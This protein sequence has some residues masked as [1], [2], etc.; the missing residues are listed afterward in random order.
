VPNVSWSPHS[1]RTT[2]SAGTIAN[3]FPSVGRVT[4]LV[5]DG[6]DGNGQWGGRVTSITVR[7]TSGDATTTGIGFRSAFG[8]RSEWFRVVLP[9]APPTYVR[10]TRAGS[11]ATVSWR[12][13]SPNGGATITGYTVRLS[14]GGAAKSVGTAARTA[15]FSGLST[16]TDYVASVVATSGVGPSHA[17]TVTTKVRRLGGA[18]TIRAAAAVSRA[19]F[20]DDAAKAVVLV[21]AGHRA[22]AMS[23]GPLAAA[24]H[25][26]V[27]V[28]E[29]STLPGV[30]G[31][32]L[33][34]VAPAGA[35][36]YLLGN[37]GAI[38]D[39]VATTVQSD[40][41]HPARVTGDTTAAAAVAVAHVV[42]RTTTVSAAYEV[43]GGSYADAWSATPAAVRAHAVL[44]VTN[45]TAQAP[46]TAAWI[47][48]HSGLPRFAVGADAQQADPAATAVGGAGS[49]ATAIALA[50]STFSSPRLV[51]VLA[52]HG[53]TALSAA[54]RL[55]RRG[56]LVYAPSGVLP[57]GV[58]SYLA[59]HRGDIVGVELVGGGLPYYRVESGTQSALLG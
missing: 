11:A 35:T 31:A 38:A 29:P 8:L 49:V 52:G 17:A 59:G 19:T 34:R 12:P 10:A 21:A 5:V 43:A 39:S 57:S 53:F 30:T 2:L 13:P 51:G 32:E 44:L 20:P 45:G 28:T 58:R 48:N 40:G 4:S 27:L 3:A 41:F 14:P 6:R 33:K 1:W 37:T 47:A 24:V 55:G 23:A 25:A 42:A 54:V 46:E 36:V 18:R 50:R 7:G 56:P 9:P 26:P 22:A 16:G 15:S